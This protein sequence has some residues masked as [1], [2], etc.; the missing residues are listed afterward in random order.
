[1]SFDYNAPSPSTRRA[2]IEIAWSRSGRSRSPTVA[3]HPEGVDR[4]IAT[5]GTTLS[6]PRV[7]L[8]PE[9]V[10]RNA[11]PKRQRQKQRTSPSTRRAWIE[12][13]TV[14]AMVWRASVALHPEGVD[15][16]IYAQ[17]KRTR[18]CVA[19]HPEG[20]DRNYQV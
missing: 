12:I 15:R 11:R 5:L 4:N 9:G 2:W 10:D 6:A 16:N 13:G 8:H 3:L 20:V 18:C 7:A 19:L 1:M 17:R 14:P